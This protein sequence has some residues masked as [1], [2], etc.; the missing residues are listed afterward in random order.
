MATAGSSTSDPRAAIAQEPGKHADPASFRVV[1]YAGADG[2]GT[3]V[4]DGEG[5][6]TDHGDDMGDMG[7]MEGMDH[8]SGTDD[9]TGEPATEEHGDHG[10]PAGPAP[11]RPRAVVL[12]SFAALNGGVLLTAGFMRRRTKERVQRSKSARAAALRQ[13]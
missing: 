3:E 1:S 6:H 7:D 9:S 11:T 13:S 12:G 10:E 2:G 5:E 8:G 4:E